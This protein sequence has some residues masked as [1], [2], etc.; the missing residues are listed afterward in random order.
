MCSFLTLLE[1]GVIYLSQHLG[2]LISH[3]PGS[4]FQDSVVGSLEEAGILHKLYCY[5]H[6]SHSNQMCKIETTEGTQAEGASPAPSGHSAMCSQVGEGIGGGRAPLN[7]GAHVPLRR[8]LY[9]DKVGVLFGSL[10][11]ALPAPPAQSPPPC[12]PGS[13]KET[14]L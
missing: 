6:N 9:S 8:C 2:L 4:S 5:Q 1:S 14:C 3:S 13:T 10:E 11:S 7:T 12:K